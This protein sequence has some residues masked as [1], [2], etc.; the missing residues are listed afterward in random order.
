MFFHCPVQF[1]QSDGYSS[2]AQERGVPSGNLHFPYPCPLGFGKGAEHKAGTAW[3]KSGPWSDGSTKHASVHRE[4]PQVPDP[5][6]RLSFVGGCHGG[7]GTG[8]LCWVCEQHVSA[9]GTALTLSSVSDVKMQSKGSYYK[10]CSESNAF[11]DIGPMMSEVGV[12][13]MA[14]DKITSRR[15]VACV[16][17][18][19]AF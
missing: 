18:W 14:V 2:Y 15:D 6:A 5:S 4:L 8:G 13:W 7:T 10:G 3:S 12:G 16:F 11:S 9:T 17:T 1:L 19:A